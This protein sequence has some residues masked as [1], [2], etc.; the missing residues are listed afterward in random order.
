MAPKCVG[1][2]M[3]LMAA[4]MPACG[5]APGKAY[6]PADSPL[7]PYEAPE[8]GAVTGEDD[9]GF[10]L[11]EEALDEPATDE[12]ANAK[13]ADAADKTAAPTATPEATAASDE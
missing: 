4:L 13:A 1:L 6:I 12:G 7:T 10:T 5:G 2:V 9:F 8:E 11:D 3:I